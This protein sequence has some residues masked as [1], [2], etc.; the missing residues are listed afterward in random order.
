MCG[1]IEWLMKSFWSWNVVEEELG[2]VIG[3]IYGDYYGVVYGMIWGFNW[4]LI[5]RKC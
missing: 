2:G 1:L 5:E 3:K 4:Q